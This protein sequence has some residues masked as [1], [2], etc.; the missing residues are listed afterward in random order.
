MSKP[1]RKKLIRA[2]NKLL[3]EKHQLERE[4]ACLFNKSVVSPMAATEFCR[5][6]TRSLPGKKLPHLRVFPKKNEKI[7]KL[8]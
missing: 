5:Q 6:A 7:S 1:T 3:K 2:F 4:K 8:N